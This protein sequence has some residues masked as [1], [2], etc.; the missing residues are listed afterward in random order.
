MADQTAIINLIIAEL[1]G[2]TALI[3]AL[4]VHRNPDVPPPTDAEVAAAY[5]AVL[6]SSLQKD[7]DWLANHPE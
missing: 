3:K 7:A 2:V 6:T 4:F 5:Q 1:P